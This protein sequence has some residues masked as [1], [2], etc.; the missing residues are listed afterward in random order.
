MAKGRY[1]VDVDALID[2][3]P[4]G[5]RQAG[6]VFLCGL[7]ALF[8]GMDNQ[9]IGLVA[10]V[11]TKELDIAPNAFGAVF[12]LSL[13]GTAVGAFLLGPLADRVGRKKVLIG[14]TFCFGIFTIF[15]ALATGLPEL[16]IYRFLTGIGLGGAIPS[17]VSLTSEYA[18]K[19]HRVVFISLLWAGIPLGGVLGAFLASWLVPLY[20]WSSLFWVGGVLPVILAFVLVF[21]L[22]ESVGF[23]VNANASEERIIR[24]LRQV[25]PRAEV[26]ADAQFVRTPAS[27]A[28]ASVRL[29][30]DAGRT[31]L[32]SLLWVCFFFTFLMLATNA[33]WTPTL[34]QQADLQVGQSA[35]VM[36]VFNAGS[37]VGTLLSGY[38][39]KR[40]A[41][42]LLL[43]AVFAATAAA[44]GW[45]GQAAGSV[46]F[47]ASLQGVAGACLGI[48]T[49]ALVALAATLYPT[50]IR[51]TAVGW[52]MGMGRFGAFAGPVAV[53]LFV[54]WG[55]PMSSVFLAFGVPAL[56]VA[57][58]AAVLAR[59]NR[60]GEGGLPRDDAEGAAGFTTDTRYRS[61]VPKN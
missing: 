33:A 50:A 38:A 8:D 44:F 22:P 21:A 31:K 1:E 29:L 34:L 41:P 3:Q 26:P 37:V 13:A 19:R 23:L 10:P 55:W 45:V 16:L 18:P 42:Q 15:T 27:V 9:A 35:V 24:L 36:A 32:T 57:L 25:F 2:T 6:I 47:V 20:G 43:P 54:S 52:A 58:A 46:A 61:I 28:S 49:P 30:F 48:G 17:F 59:G 12:S 14:S 5:W 4:F 51:S 53:G 39:I 40:I 56:I 7:I 11:M 60:T